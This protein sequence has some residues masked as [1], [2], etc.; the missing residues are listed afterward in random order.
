MSASSDSISTSSAWPSVLEQLQAV[1]TPQAVASVRCYRN[2]EFAASVCRSFSESFHASGQA[3]DASPYEAAHSV[4]HAISA[5][6]Q[7]HATASL[8]SLTAAVAQ[9]EL[10]L[11]LIE[12]AHQ[13]A[14]AS[15][16]IAKALQLEALRCS[17]VYFCSVIYLN[18]QQSVAG[19]PSARPPKVGIGCSRIR[20][21]IPSCLLSYASACRCSA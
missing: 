1:L 7:Q 6:L 13:A 14:K 8:K 10:V 19:R 17:P 9:G 4:L 21:S 11:P 5:G 16:R 3:A 15:G 2:L 18:T 20:L 12:D